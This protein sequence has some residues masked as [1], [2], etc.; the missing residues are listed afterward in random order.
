MAHSD[1]LRLGAVCPF[2][3]ASL[4]PTDAPAPGGRRPTVQPV[5]CGSYTP[6]D[7]TSWRSGTELFVDDLATIDRFHPDDNVTLGYLTLLFA[8]TAPDRCAICHV[9]PAWNYTSRCMHCYS[10]R[11]RK[12][13]DWD[14]RLFR[15]RDEPPKWPLRHI[16]DLAENQV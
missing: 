7:V 8:L 14:G 5:G 12:G 9:R 4:S 13:V 6:A 3:V 10:W 15:L 1:S 2:N 11:R 16:T